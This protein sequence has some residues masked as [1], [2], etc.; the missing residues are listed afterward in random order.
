MTVQPIEIWSRCLA[1]LE[2]NLSATAFKMWFQPIVPLQYEN[3]VL[4]LQV[5]SSYVVEYIEENYIDLLRKVFFRVCGRGAR[6]EYRVLIDSTSGS[7]S[8][9]P[10][11][12]VAEEAQRQSELIVNKERRVLPKEENI[13]VDFDSQLNDK[14]SFHSFVGGESNRL[15][16]AAGLTIAGNPGNTV[17]NPLFVYG[18][19]GVGKT[20]LLN[21]IGNEIRKAFPSKRVLYVSA[22]TFQVQYMNAIVNKQFND[23]MNFYQ[24]IDVLLVD[25]VQFFSSREGTQ[26]AFFAIFNHLHQTG[27]Q[28]ILT[29]DRSPVELQGLQDRLITRFKWGL[30]AE[31]KQPDFQLR[32]DILRASIYRNG[33][34]VE[35]EIVS[36][37]AEN[38]RDNVRDL[39]GVLAS[40]YAHS[41]LT[42]AQI[43]MRLTEEVVARLVKVK[44]SQ[45]SIENIASVVCEQFKI[46]E[47]QLLSKSRRKEIAQARQ[48]AMWLAKRMT[49]KSLAEIGLNL[50]NRNHATVFHAIKQVNEQMQYDAVFRRMVH[51]IENIL[52]R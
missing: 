52:V 31:L 2:D 24:T 4:I 34:E 16:R 25:D 42:N 3:N 20:H 48:V 39:D 7:S 13:A 19:S 30:T 28:L 14:Y 5:S 44:D 11:Q 26:N 37:I 36:Y 9:I 29:S 27:K 32:K 12:G 41:T 51:Q 40:L 10:S 43:D 8:I 38:V 50:G 18:G 17:F 33:L 22:S 21:A 45:A 46:T 1:I 23:F 49:E 6:L 47:A 35:E 15:A